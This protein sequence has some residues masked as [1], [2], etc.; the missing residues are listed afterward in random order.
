MTDIRMIYSTVRGEY[1]KASQALITP[2]AK[3]ATLTIKGTADNV[4]IGGRSNIAAAG[5]SKKWQNA[6]RVNVYPK[7]VDSVDASLY[8]YHKI[9]YAGVFETGMTI[10]GNPMLWIPL[11]GIPLRFGGRR[12]TPKM[13]VATI[14]PLHSVNIPGKPPMLAAYLSAGAT[15]S[16]ITVR[17]LKSGALIKSKRGIN[18]V[19]SVPIFYGVS[20]V[21]LAAKFNLK[22]VF[23]KAKNSLGKLYLE[24][25]RKI[26][27]GS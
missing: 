2:I 1:A 8:A 27:N 17:K 22:E 11:P 19:I 15:T 20:A 21:K 4:K 26:N 9:P 25:M 16:N 10:T 18:A 12:L 3:A 5:F 14:G 23:N 13:F 6:F 24:N 7:K